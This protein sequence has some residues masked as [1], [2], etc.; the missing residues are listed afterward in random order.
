MKCP[1]LLNAFFKSVLSHG[2]K[3]STVVWLASLGTLPF[4]QLTASRNWT[5]NSQNSSQKLISF[6]N[7]AVDLV[8]QEAV[9][10]V[11]LCFLDCK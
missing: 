8:L 2:H 3:A 6:Q 11:F 4:E 1:H 10:S 5:F 7:S 9:F